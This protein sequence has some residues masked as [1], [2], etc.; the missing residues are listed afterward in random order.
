MNFNEVMKS[1]SM[2]NFTVDLV[3]N[4]CCC[5]Q[6]ATGRMF[7]FESPTISFKVHVDLGEGDEFAP[8]D[9]DKVKG[10]H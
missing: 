2:L 6:A 9:H 1:R 10:F 7:P 8:I 3:T 4:N 5:S